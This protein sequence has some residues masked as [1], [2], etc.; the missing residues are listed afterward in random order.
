[1][2]V[3]ELPARARV[4]VHARHPLEPWTMLS[5]R[6][7]CPGR[8]ASDAPPLLVQ[9]H[10]VAAV[11]A[12]SEASDVPLL[13]A[14]LLWGAWNSLHPAGPASRLRRIPGSR[15]RAHRAGPFHHA[16]LKDRTILARRA[17]LSLRIR[18][19]AAGLQSASVEKAAAQ[20]STSDGPAARRS[21]AEYLVRCVLSLRL[22]QPQL[23][24]PSA[25]FRL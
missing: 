6:Q 12:R 2:S 25:A 18:A 7:P 4:D 21:A 11:A 19:T 13:F 1:M 8:A 20:G 15:I 10:V 24:L 3:E 23:P 5:L 22:N 9:V 16:S 17:K 14:L